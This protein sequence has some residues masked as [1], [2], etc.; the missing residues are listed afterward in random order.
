MRLYEV[1]ISGDG[2]Q[3]EPLYVGATSVPE[4]VEKAQKRYKARFPNSEQ[5]VKS[6][7]DHG[8]LIL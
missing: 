5:A 6:V 2:Y 8:A 1:A 7:K 3:P 4:A